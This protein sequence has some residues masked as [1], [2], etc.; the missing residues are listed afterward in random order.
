MNNLTKKELRKQRAALKA[1]YRN[2]GQLTSLSAE[3]LQRLEASP[4]FLQADVVMLYYSL[5]DEVDTHDFVERWAQ[6]KQ[7]ILPVVVGDDLELRTYHGRHEL[8]KG[9]YGIE[10]PTGPRFLHPEQIECIVV[11]GVAFDAQGNRLGRGKGYYDRLLPHLQQAYK[12]GLCFPFQRVEMVPAEPF[13]IC[14]DE[15]IS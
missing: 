10:E 4:R 6:T 15:V 5:P 14:M 9:A 7:I 13:D 1:T 12:I 2:A 3:V 11:P 8:A